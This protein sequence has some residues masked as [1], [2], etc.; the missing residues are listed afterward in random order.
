MYIVHRDKEKNLTYN[1]TFD[2]KINTTDLSI[3]LGIP[4]SYILWSKIEHILQSKSIQWLQL[5]QTVNINAEKSYNRFKQVLQGTE[6]QYKLYSNT[7]IMRILK[8]IATS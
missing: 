7:M 1:S 3:D 4:Y 6:S 2:M 5:N 8:H